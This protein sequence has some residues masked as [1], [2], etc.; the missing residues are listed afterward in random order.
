MNDFVLRGFCQHEKCG[1]SIT[2]KILENERDYAWLHDCLPNFVGTHDI[3]PSA[4]LS[5]KQM[6]IIRESNHPELLEYM[7][8][9]HL[10]R[11]DSWLFET[12]LNNNPFL[13]AK[14]L[15]TSHSTEEGVKE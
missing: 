8:E 5:P 10:W 11:L 7:K 6:N 9:A 12:L 14:I 4:V 3:I 15:S 1:Y 2:L 13:V